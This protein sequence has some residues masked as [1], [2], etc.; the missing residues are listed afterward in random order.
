[1][2]NAEFEDRL[3]TTDGWIHQRTGIRARRVGGSTVD[4]ATAALSGALAAAGVEGGDLGAVVLATSTPER[5]L[6]AAAATVGHRLGLRCGGFDINAACAGFVYAF[7]TGCGL[8]AAGAEHVAVVGADTL[9]RLADPDDRATAF[10]FGDGAAALI[11]SRSTGAG[12]VLGWDSGTDPGAIDLLHSEHGAFLQMDGRE[13]FRRAVRAVVSS[14]R[15]ALATAGLSPADVDLFVPHQANLRIIEAAAERLGIAMS[16][17]EVIIEETAN[18]S[19]ASV[20]LALASATGRGA[21]PEGGVVL[22]CGFGAGLTWASA[23][24]RW[25]TGAPRA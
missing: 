13:V 17:V 6:P 15:R 3:D 5:S 1:M 19:A 9:S 4:L 16:R 20:P 8:V 2:A 7:V 25:D 22:L 18:T 23:V 24:V 14:C 11:L 21:I 12:G 10:L